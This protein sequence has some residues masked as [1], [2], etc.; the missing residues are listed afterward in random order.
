MLDLRYLGGGREFFETE[1]GAEGRRRKVLKEYRDYGADALKLTNDE[2]IE[3]VRAKKRLSVYGATIVDALDFYEKNHAVQEP[4]LFSEA[5]KRVVEVKRSSKKDSEYVRKFD[6]SMT[7]LK[8]VVGDK[9]LSTVTRDEIEAWLFGSGWKQDTIRNKRTDVRTFF[10]YAQKRH[11]ITSNP[12]EHLENV[13]RTNKPPGILKVEECERLLKACATLELKYF[14]PYVALNLLCGIRCEETVKLLPENIQIEQGFVEVPA[15]RGD[16]EIAKSRKRRIVAM[17]E[18][19]KDW[20]NLCDLATMK[21]Q[22]PKWFARQ[23]PKIRKAASLDH[24][25]KNCLRHSFASYHLAMHG[26]ADK[27]ATELG[28]H[29]TAMLFQHYRELVT[30]DDA[31]KFWRIRPE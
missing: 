27:T 29:S 20:F 25:P 19:A 28:H 18:S 12:A 9:L 2:R 16:V 30:K 15:F 14:L 1:D 13:E 26:S 22:T 8:A 10:A 31:E 23:L 3:F 6:S 21:V 11:W 24:W 4:I 7:A 5:I 17:S